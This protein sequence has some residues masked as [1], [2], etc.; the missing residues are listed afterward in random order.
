MR[1]MVIAIIRFPFIALAIVFIASV[2]WLNYFPSEEN[3]SNE[4]LI[5]T[6]SPALG[7]LR[8]NMIRNTWQ[9]SYRGPPAT[10]RFILASA[11][12][13]WM[14]LIEA[15]NATYG[16]LIMLSHLSDSKELGMKTKELDFFQWLVQ[17][18]MRWRY[19]SK[20]DD[21]SYLDAT[22]FYKRL[23]GPLLMREP[24]GNTM[25]ARQL[26][27][28]NPEFA[29]PGG[30]FYTL[31][32][33]LIEALAAAYTT[34]P[35]RD[36]Y[37]DLVIGRLLHDDNVEFDFIQMGNSVAFDFDAKNG[38]KDSWSHSI[39]EGSLNPHQLKDNEIFLQVAREMEELPS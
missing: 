28:H 39:T 31:S 27:W 36:D 12:E 5:A 16:D 9:K 18:G 3:R 37:A 1:E 4:W 35:V 33:P 34:K 14:P 8:R 11:G 10:M 26:Y 13:Q 22:G 32:W 21:D 20:L 19:V 7:Q 25:I 29:Y 15:E 23:L 6:I 2:L 38:D 24:D 30:Q 17:S